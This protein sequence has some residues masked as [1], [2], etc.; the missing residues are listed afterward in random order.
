MNYQ[1]PPAPSYNPYDQPHGFDTGNPFGNQAPLGQEYPPQNV[2]PPVQHQLPWQQQQPDTFA[3][4]FVTQPL[5]WESTGTNSAPLDDWMNV[6]T[7]ATTTT[8][9]NPFDLNLKAD[10]TTL[11]ESFW[12]MDN[13]DMN[14][15]AIFDEDN[16]KLEERA[17]Q[18]KAERAAAERRRQQEED[19]AFARKLQD[20]EYEK[21]KI[22]AE[23]PQA[24]RIVLSSTEIREMAEQEIG[25]DNVRI[26]AGFSVIKYGREGRPKQRKMWVNS[27]LTYVSI[28]LYP[29]KLDQERVEP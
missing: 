8:E 17:A 18:E 28:H 20:E 26:M 1:Q 7:T 13:A 29:A 24:N 9:T 25:K 19:E 14:P 22:P 23:T 16:S 3:P 10:T 2:G 21:A 5:P 11:D 27:S 4:E 6:P 15:L 12:R